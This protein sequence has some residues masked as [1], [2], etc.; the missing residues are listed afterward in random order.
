M[1]WGWTELEGVCK[2]LEGACKE[3]EEL[4]GGEL[5]VALEG[6][7]QFICI[8]SSMPCCRSVRMNLRRSSAS[9]FL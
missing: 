2:E 7:A 5:S 8:H 1:G 9:C 6:G 4:V 3:L